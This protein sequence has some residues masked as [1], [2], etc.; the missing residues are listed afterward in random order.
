MKQ[1]SVGIGASRELLAARYLRQKGYKIQQLNYRCAVGEI[2]IVARLSGIYV[3]VEVRS[4]KNDDFGSP[5]ESV[6]EFKRRRIVK[7]AHCYIKE[8]SLYNSDFRFDV[9]AFSG[10]R[11]EHYEN[12]FDAEG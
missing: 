2:D 12:A 9:V 6:D 4:R 11:L 10:G 8:H 5:E 7:T 3:F 1:T